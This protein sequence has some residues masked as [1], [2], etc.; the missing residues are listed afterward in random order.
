M[1][2]TEYG[3]ANPKALTHNK[4]IRRDDEL[5]AVIAG[6]ARKGDYAEGTSARLNAKW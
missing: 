4:E 1:K 2:L 3:F 5:A 6:R